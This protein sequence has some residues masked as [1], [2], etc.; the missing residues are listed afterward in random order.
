MLS[1]QDQNLGLRDR[2]T[3]AHH[4]GILTGH[5]SAANTTA[6]A[7]TNYNESGKVYTLA[8]KSKRHTDTDV[9]VPALN[10]V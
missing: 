5:V 2:S 6:R 9:H 10:H 1:C 7:V 3:E 8:I 4:V